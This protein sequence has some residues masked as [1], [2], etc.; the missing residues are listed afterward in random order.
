L[1]D[2]STNVT[3]NHRWPQ[4]PLADTITARSRKSIRHQLRA[5]QSHRHRYPGRPLRDLLGFRVEAVAGRIETRGRSGER[6]PDG[7]A[8]EALSHG[9]EP[10]S[11]KPKRS[12]T[13]LVVNHQ[14]G[15][16]GRRARRPGNPDSRFDR[17]RR[18][19]NDFERSRRALDR[20]PRRCANSIMGSTRDAQSSLLDASGEVARQIK[21]MSRYASAALRR[22]RALPTPS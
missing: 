13:T 10:M 14:R 1:I 4:C 2:G 17:C 21:S 22:R 15:D 3:E 11:R 6:I 5:A 20:G 16:P 9:I 12:L 7:T 19:A 18:S 8:L